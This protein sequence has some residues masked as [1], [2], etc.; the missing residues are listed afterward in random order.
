MY[1]KYASKADRKN[2]A[3]VGLV[4]LGS[5]VLAL[6]ITFYIAQRQLNVQLAHQAIPIRNAV[7]NLLEETRRVAREAQGWVGKTCNR[8]LE[9]RLNALPTREMRMLVIN[10][11]DGDRITC[12][13][14][15][16]NQGARV[17]LSGFSAQG[18]KIDDS[19]ASA[20]I[21]VFSL[22]QRLANGGIVVSADLRYLWG[23][24][25]NSNRD[26][27]FALLVN[28]KLLTQN[29]ILVGE[30]AKLGAQD[31]PQRQPGG[32][33]TLAWRSPD[34]ADIWQEI[35]GSW[36][37]ILV[38]LVPPL[39]LTTLAWS[40]LTRRRSLYQHLVNAV[41]QDRIT[42]YYQPIICA[43]SNRVIGAEILARWEH[44]EIG[45]VPP[46]IFIPVA[47][48]TNTIGLMTENL[49]KRV[50][51]DCQRPDCVLPDGFTFNVN[52]S[53]A[54]LVA[55]D[56]NAFT[57]EF[58]ARFK[59]L[60]LHLTFEFTENEQINFNDDI[61]NKIKV[62]RDSGIAI[63]LDDFGTGF[64][65]L[66]WIA[67]LSPD[68]IKIDRMFINQISPDASTPLINCVIDMARQMGI[69]TVA[70]GVEHDYQ[71]AWLQ[72]NE[73]DF[74][75]GYFYSKPLPFAAFIDY[76]RHDVMTQHLKMPPLPKDTS[77]QH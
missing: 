72:E 60:H 42:P 19:V 47:E 18:V 12:S 75:Q 56:F 41:H 33:Y 43:H 3:L 15:L 62:V 64:S 14:L 76:F 32:L 68:S 71:V 77:L 57:S 40:L 22:Y 39:L 27:R 6:W 50:L 54:H 35:L 21:P 66:S 51:A 23:I 36:L 70:E 58:A 9:S 67:S 26:E 31:Y 29:G 4:F 25:G 48:K 7:E 49:L 61:L 52:I 8:Q 1:K 28:N 65:N 63:S 34:T 30:Q 37:Y 53:H 59:R 69:Q 10:L 13:S 16:A 5:V 73:I 17:D 11:L 44:P 46:D 38:I 2:Y 20:G 74:F 55:E 45:F 24:M